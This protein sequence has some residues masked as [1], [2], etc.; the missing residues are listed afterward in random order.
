MHAGKLIFSLT[1]HFSPLHR[2]LT[3]MI[4]KYVSVD[5]LSA[6]SHIGVYFAGNECMRDNLSGEMLTSLQCTVGFIHLRLMSGFIR[7]DNSG[8]RLSVNRAGCPP[9]G[10][11]VV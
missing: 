11:L 6:L 10:G 5:S 3:A 8:R 2:P 9:I 1:S 7:D 4:A